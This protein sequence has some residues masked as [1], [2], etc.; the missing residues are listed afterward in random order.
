ME[1]L[2]KKAAKPQIIRQLQKYFFEF[3]VLLLPTLLKPMAPLPK[4]N[5]SSKIKKL[6][7]RYKKTE[8]TKKR[9]T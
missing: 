7:Y 3:S 8:I 5:S 6:W 4:I 2:E 9:N 1:R